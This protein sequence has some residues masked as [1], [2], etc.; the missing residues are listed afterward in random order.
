M[1][2]NISN[3]KKLSILYKIE[4]KTIYYGILSHMLI[5]RPIFQKKK[6]KRQFNQ[7]LSVAYIATARKGFVRNKSGPS[8]LM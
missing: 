1:T 5:R 8:F 2:Q 3:L 7:W 6:K 4:L